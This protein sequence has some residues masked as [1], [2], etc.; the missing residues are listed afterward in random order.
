MSR[1]V[2]C[3][4]VQCFFFCAQAQYPVDSIPSEEAEKIIRFLASDSLKGRG[5]GTKELTL[6]ADFIASRFGQAGLQPLPEAGSFFLP[7]AARKHAGSAQNNSDTLYN[8]VAVLPGRSKPSEM[9]IFSAHYD[10]IGE[11]DGVIYNGAN[12]NASGTTALLLLADYFV[13]RADNERT[14]IFCAFAGEEMGLLGSKAFV[15][16]VE[17]DSI[18]AVINIEMIGITSVGKNAFYMTGAQYSSLQNIF[19][20]NVA[21]KYKIRSEPDYRKNLFGRSD[22]FPFAQKG[23]PAHT[24]MASDDDDACYHQSCDDAKRINIENMTSLVR[25][26]ALGSATIIS[27]KDTPTRIKPRWLQ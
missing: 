24:I 6:T 13:R 17:P 20:K 21:G 16:T 10:H 23:V 5:N 15:Q 27:G 22:N 1:Y 8:I 19:K 12:D 14:I 3:L 25:A 11:W 9:V 26:I 4:L 7:F 18:L 2:S